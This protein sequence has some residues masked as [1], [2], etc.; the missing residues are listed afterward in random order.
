[1]CPHICVSL[2]AVDVPS[3]DV[4]LYTTI[5]HAVRSFFS[6]LSTTPHLS[7][8]NAS[9]ATFISIIDDAQY[10]FCCPRSHV[11]HSVL[12]LDD[13][14][15]LVCGLGCDGCPGLHVHCTRC[16]H[17]E[18][19]V[20][21]LLHHC[22]HRHHLHPAPTHHGKDIRHINTHCHAVLAELLMLEPDAEQFPFM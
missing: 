12:G 20:Q 8:V 9:E 21:T 4:F 3:F 17:Q 10:V 18:Q 13:R 2:L 15:V 7:C 11:R 16:R 14:L 1:M 19:D 6:P 22:Q 5:G